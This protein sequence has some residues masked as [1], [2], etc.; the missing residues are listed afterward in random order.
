MF[1]YP[2][3]DHALPHWTYMYCNDMLTVNVSILLTKKH[4]I[5]IKTQPHQFGFTFITSLHVVLIMVE[6]HRRTRK[7]VTCVNK[8]LHQTNLQ[9][10][11]PENN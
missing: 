4:I 9:N 7:Y 8:N 5:S 2:Q 11:T 6:F 1:S 3:Y 10:F